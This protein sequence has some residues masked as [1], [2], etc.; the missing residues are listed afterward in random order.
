MRVPRLI[1]DL[2]RVPQHVPN[3][4][5]GPLTRPRPLLRSTDLS[6]NL[7][8]GQLI[9][10]GPPGGYSD[11]SQTFPVVHQPIPDLSK[12]PPTR[13]GTPAGSHDLSRAS[14]RVP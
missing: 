7:P 6:Q 8:E 3:L 14:G 9:R 12:C 5:D 13:S 11:P 1:P 4:W 2:L 10:P